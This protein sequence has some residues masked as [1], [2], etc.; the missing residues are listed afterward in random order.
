QIDRVSIPT[1][2]SPV[3]IRFMVASS[4]S[5]TALELGGESLR[6]SASTYCSVA[7]RREERRDSCQKC[8]AEND[9]RLAPAASSFATGRL[10]AQRKVGVW[11]PTRL[12]SLYLRLA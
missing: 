6:K 8:Q 1:R 12:A 2:R 11:L 3:L 5:V 9:A 7:A 10:M 4:L